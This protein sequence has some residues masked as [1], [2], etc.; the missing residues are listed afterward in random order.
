M[1]RTSVDEKVSHAIERVAD[2][3]EEDVGSFIWSAVVSIMDKKTSETFE[4][5]SM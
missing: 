4:A 5:Y 3:D 2:A 1:K